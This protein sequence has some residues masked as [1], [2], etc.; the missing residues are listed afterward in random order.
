MIKR[1]NDLI[2]CHPLQRSGIKEEQQW[3][4]R[5]E[6]E[7]ADVFCLREGGWTSAEVS[8]GGGEGLLLVAKPI[9]H[10][11]NLMFLITNVCCLCALNTMSSQGILC[12]RVLMVGKQPPMGR[13]WS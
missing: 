13:I 7:E 11:L 5:A 6:I 2:F 1:S 12:Y 4:E 10:A 8:N 3:R 9:A